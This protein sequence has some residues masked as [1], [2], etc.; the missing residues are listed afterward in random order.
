[1][2][3]NK[4][5]LEKSALQR[6]MDK[7][8]A[9]Q[10][11]SLNRRFQTKPVFFEMPLMRQQAPPIPNRATRAGTEGRPSLNLELVQSTSG[12]F[13]LIKSRFDLDLVESEL[14]LSR[15]DF[16]LVSNYLD[17]LAWISMRNRLLIIDMRLDHQHR[18]DFWS[19]LAIRAIR[20]L[21]RQL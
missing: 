8:N 18:W 14:D 11:M 6:P 20:S 1:M 13:C 19:A 21:N 2:V 7:A 10:D 4:G 16:V 12:A 15:N 3:F 9:D 17:I 5:R